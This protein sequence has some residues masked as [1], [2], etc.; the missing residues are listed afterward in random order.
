MRIQVI[1]EDEKKINIR[2]PN[3]IL[4]SRIAWRF[5]SGKI[6]KNG[7]TDD[8]ELSAMLRK[9]RP[10][11]KRNLKRVKKKNSKFTLVEVE[12]EDGDYVKITL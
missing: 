3:S 4:T 1:S 6:D 12:S 11:L 7:D 8:C 10:E 2:L 9:L 5:I